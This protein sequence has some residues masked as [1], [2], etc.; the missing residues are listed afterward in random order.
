MQYVI[1]FLEG[2]ITFI[3]PCLLPMLPIYISYFAGGEQRTTSKTFK[4]AIGFVTGFTIV[5]VMLGA[6]A[7][8]VGSF[9]KEYQ[10]VVNIVS[11]LI[12]IV[13]GLNF[14]GVFK[15]NLFK[16]SQKSVNTDGMGFF[17][18]MLFGVVFSI[19]WTPCVGAFLGSALMLASQQAH[20]IEGMLM[21]LLYSLGL[22]IP[23]ILSAVLIDYLKGAFDWI[24]K[25]YKVINTISGIMLVLIGMLMATGMMKKILGLLG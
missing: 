7:G 24:K 22:G 16:D 25:N 18:A 1:A 6:L 4:G 3:S 13:F 20:V 10:T 12:V 2:I 23:F 15:L 21:L 8:T 17:S 9:L 11:G 5:F 14:L 19:G